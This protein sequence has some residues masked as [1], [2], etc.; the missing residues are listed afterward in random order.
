[1]NETVISFP[2]FGEN[3]KLCPSRSIELFGIK[4]Y[5]Y[6]IIIATGFILAFLYVMKRSKDFNL[7][8]DNVLDMLLITVPL[9][10]VGS[11]LYYVAF[12]FERYRSDDFLEMLKKIVNIRNGG[13]AIYGA[14]IASVISVVI[15]CRVRKLSVGDMTDLGSLGLLIGQCVG[16]WGNFINREAFGCETTLPWRMGLTYADGTTIFVHPTFFYESLWNFI[17]F[18]WISAYSKKPRKFK[19]QI[20]A[21]YAVWYG[22]GRFWVEWLRVNTDS[23]LLINTDTFKLPISVCVAAASVIAGTVFLIYK[24]KITN[25]NTNTESN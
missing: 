22:L 16:R 5:W 11:R 20:F 19:G 15:F 14:V 9:A 18:L 8:Q 23:L 21:L 25:S 10:I 2:L 3:F 24:T 17:G 4:F 7:T 13:L 12:D 6:G 1:M